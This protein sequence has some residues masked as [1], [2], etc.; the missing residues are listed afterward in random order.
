M[1]NR[2]ARGKKA[3]AM[4]DVCGFEFELKRLRALVVKT[5][6]TNILACPQCWVKDH[7]QLLLG[8]YPVHD[9]QALRNPRPDNTYWQAGMTGLRVDPHAPPASVLAFGTPSGGSRVIQWGWNPVGLNDVLGLPGLVDVMEM[10]G[11]IGQVEI[12]VSTPAIRPTGVEAVGDI[13]VVEVMTDTGT[14]QGASGV[15]GIGTVVVN[16]P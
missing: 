10:H 2:F 3:I 7:P 9:P 16:T 8:M 14:P 11:Q 13:G 1:S 4:C 6:I 12:E 15:S 5:K